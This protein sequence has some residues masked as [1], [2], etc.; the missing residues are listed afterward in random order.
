MV[1]K[2]AV[3]EAESVVIPASEAELDA[4]RKSFATLTGDSG[5]DYQKLEA[6]S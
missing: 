5:A 3:P 6:F 1:R 2:V 4:G